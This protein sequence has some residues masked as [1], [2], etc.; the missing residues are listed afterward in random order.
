MTRVARTRTRTLSATGLGTVCWGPPGPGCYPT[1]GPSVTGTET[2]VDSHGTPWVNSPL[3]I[4]WGRFPSIHVSGTRSD[5]IW[6]YTITHVPMNQGI[7]DVMKAPWNTPAL[8][9]APQSEATLAAKAI[10][11]INPNSPKVDLAVSILELRELPELLRD[12]GRIAL[13]SDRRVPR[14]AKANLVAQF[15]ILPIVSDIK[16][17]LK[18]TELVSKREAQLRK[19][20]VK[21][22]RFKRTLMKESWSGS[23]NGYTC[24]HPRVDTSGTSKMDIS[25]MADR[26][27]WYT[28]NAH[29]TGAWDER[30]IQS[31]AFRTTL[32]LDTVSAS[33]LWELLPWSW[34]IDWFSNT[35]DILAAYR[36]GIPWT[37][38]NLCVMHKTTYYTTGKFNP[39]KAGLTVDLLNPNGKA[40]EKVRFTPLLVWTLPEFTVPYLT[41]SQWSILASLAALRV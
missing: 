34:L 4:K 22:A 33:S 29:L 14:T 39:L 19:M 24:F 6:T 28:I 3:N 40:T 30:E 11:N 1:I 32:G 35:G 38:S 25:V 10:A 20:K 12:A 15:G 17:L 7:Y 18:F 23:S 9:Q 37:W 2:C 5:A 27:Y 13:G 26:E 36:S 16:K 41:G 21:G 8:T 31:L